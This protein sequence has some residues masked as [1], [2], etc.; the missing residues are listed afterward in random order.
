MQEQP[1]AGDTVTA[2]QA[3][4]SLAG[5]AGSRAYYALGLLSA[6]NLFNYIDRN[7][8]SI[9]AEAIK[10][11][12]QISDAQLGFLLGTSFATLFA[13]VGIPAGRIADRVSRK[14][15]MAAGLALWSTMTALS[16]FAVTFTSL[17]LARVMVGVG[18]ASANPC[19]H[20]LLSDI[21][22]RRRRASA[23]SIYLAG[24]YAGQ[25]LSLAI[26]GLILAR[27]SDIC[28]VSPELLCGVRPWQAAFFIVGL[29]GLA[30]AVLITRLQEPERA[31]APNHDL[32]KLIGTEFA[33]SVPPFTFFSLL[34]VG[35]IAAARANLLLLAAVVVSAWLLVWATDS[36]AQWICVAIGSYSIGSWIQG[37][38][39]R[40]P[41]L[42]R[43]TF[44]SR[45][46]LLLVGGMATLGCMNATVN[47]WS[48][49]YAI[50]VLGLS[51]KVAGLA[52]GVSMAAVSIIGTV[53]GGF[54]TDRWKQR[55]PRA[56]IWVALLCMAGALP[57][58]GMMYL[59]HEP[60]FFFVGLVLQGLFSTGWGGAA[61]ALIQDLIEP[62]MRGTA[63]AAFSLVLTLVILA[64]GPYWA[65]KV[66][67]VTHSLG[68]GVASIHL[69]APFT[70]ILLLMAARQMGIASRQGE[71]Q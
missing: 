28:S 66:S 35:G 17:A 51:P 14:S 65:G 67:T 13:V 25:A 26:G 54:I 71:P 59:T 9:L 34:R 61:A 6:A 44:G 53:L 19:S 20:S 56:P 50:R 24:S 18:E 39:W 5:M 21:F 31:T 33:A 41:A 46:F 52:I 60:T 40:D 11:D 10:K 49:P 69:L 2:L 3:K 64:I 7:L 68:F 55:D 8:L 4:T 30:L 36:A 42:Y 27:W 37:L 62:R 12:L 63:A 47:V 22:P 29:P 58:A 45:L 48:A 1:L 38:K 70:V 43:V 15:M 32:P 16:G 57:G 23:L